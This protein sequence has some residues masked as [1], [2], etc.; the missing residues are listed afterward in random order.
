[1]LVPSAH[2][3]AVS[4][5]VNARHLNASLKFETIGPQAPAQRRP[6]AQNSLVYRVQAGH[7]AH[8]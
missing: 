2:T 8:A 5:A 4:R 7:L 3:L 1:M 6:S